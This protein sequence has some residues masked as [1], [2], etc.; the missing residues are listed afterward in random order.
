MS[1]TSDKGDY[2][3][4]RKHDNFSGRH[5]VITGGAAGIG[6]AIATRLIEGG[7]TVS[8]WDR[9]AQALDKARSTLGAQHARV[10]QVDVGDE[11]SVQSAA[12][13]TSKAAG[14]IDILVNSAG[15]TGPNTSVCEYPVAEWDQVMREIG[16]ASCRERV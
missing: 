9:D 7:A 8:L 13:G 2:M 10:E 14:A 1:A 11:N 6:L 15:I 12:D 5:A 4:A 3:P 16:R